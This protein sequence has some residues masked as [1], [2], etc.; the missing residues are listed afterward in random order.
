MPISPA[1]KSG[2]ALNSTKLS[3]AYLRVLTSGEWWCTV[4]ATTSRKLQRWRW[5]RGQ[6]KLQI[7]VQV[8]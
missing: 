7:Y 6:W 2:G 1:K 5:W 4:S 8:Q 3:K